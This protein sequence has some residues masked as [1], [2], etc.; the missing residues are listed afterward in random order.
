MNSGTYMDAS[1]VARAERNFLCDRHP[2][3]T[4]VRGH[5]SGLWLERLVRA[6]ALHETEIWEPRLP[7]HLLGVRTCSQV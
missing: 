2:R 6:P 7:S 4:T 1:L 5:I 3:G